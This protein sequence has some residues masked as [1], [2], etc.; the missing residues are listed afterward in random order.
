MTQGQQHDDN[1]LGCGRLTPSLE[2]E[3][4]DVLSGAEPSDALQAHMVDCPECAAELAELRAMTLLMIEDAQET[5]PGEHFF[6]SLHEEV[7]EGLGPQGIQHDDTSQ[8]PAHTTNDSWWSWLEPL[9][10]VLTRPSVLVGGALVAAAIALM[11]FWP[12]HSEVGHDSYEPYDVVM[13]SIALTTAEKDALKSLASSI[14]VDLEGEDDDLYASWDAEE[15]DFEGDVLWGQGV[16]G[17]IQGLSER[18]LDMVLAELN[19]SL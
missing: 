4:F 14:T 7:M 1:G 6:A 16:A 11:L 5:H 12:Q 13:P 2:A 10:T 17:S 3:W 9:R 8:A 15:E 18:E 19:K